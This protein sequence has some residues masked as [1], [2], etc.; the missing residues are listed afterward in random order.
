MSPRSLSVSFRSAVDRRMK[1]LADERDPGLT[2]GQAHGVYSGLVDGYDI[3]LEETV[4]QR[5]HGV[6]GTLKAILAK[7]A[8]SETE[9]RFTGD[10][11]P[12]QLFGARPFP[13]A[14][15]EKPVTSGSL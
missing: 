7:P 6:P 2:H 4:S 15:P 9:G 5:R 14:G 8:G 13:L 3:L 1:F 12:A 11:A 10:L